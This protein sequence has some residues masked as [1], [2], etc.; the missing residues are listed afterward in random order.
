MYFILHFC[1]SSKQWH[2]GPAVCHTE[3]HAKTKFWLCQ[4]CHDAS[5]GSILRSARFQINLCLVFS[6][7]MNKLFHSFHFTFSFLIL[8][9]FQLQCLTMPHSRHWLC[10]TLLSF[11]TYML[12]TLFT[13]IELIKRRLLG[14]HPN[15]F[16]HNYPSHRA[17]L[18]DRQC[19]N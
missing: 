12:L 6:E 16:I 2:T 7:L 18:F 10:L 15:D 19:V 13:S 4:T 14:G 9:L 8:A 11:M 5:V 1:R 17:W 3:R